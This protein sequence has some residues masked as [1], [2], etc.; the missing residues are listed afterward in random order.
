MKKQTLV[1]L[2]AAFVLSVSAC[3]AKEKPVTPSEGT[4]EVECESTD[5]TEVSIEEATEAAM[6]PGQT[7][8]G[9]GSPWIDSN[10]KENITE[11]MPV[12]VKDDFHLYVNHEW[13][14]KNNIPEGYSSNGP[15][16]TVSMDTMRKAQ[17]LI[18]DTELTGHEI[19][20]VRD[21]YWAYLDWDAKNAL[22]VE[23]VMPTVKDIQNLKTIQELSDFICDPDR[24]MFV[25]VFAGCSNDVDINNTT[26]YVTSIA[27]D[28]FLLADAAE[29][30]TRTE[31]G[32][33][34]YS[35]NKA[36][37]VNM[38]T[39]TGYQRDEAEKLYDTVIDFEAKLAEVSLTS[40]ETMDP[41]YIQ[42]TNNIM[43]MSELSQLAPEFPLERFIQ[44]QGYGAAKRFIVDEPEYFKRLN[45]LYTEDN[46]ESIKGY[47]LVNY[48][49]A[50]T[51]RLDRE[52][53]DV[54]IERANSVNGSKGNLSDEDYAFQMI[55]STLSDPLARA[56]ITKYDA[57]DKKQDITE[58]C[59]KVI[60]SYREQLK[61]EDWMSEE[62]R[63]K[64]IS[65]LDHI[66]IR[67]VY[68]DKWDD[69]SSLS[70]DGMSYT[71]MMKT[72][73]KFYDKKNQAY[74]NQK[75]DREDWNLNILECNAFYNPQDNSINIVL[76]IL[77]D[78]FYQE[79]MTKEQLY[80]SI[81]AVIGHEISHAFDTIGAQFDEN[82]N[83]ANWW[84]DEDFAAFKVKTDKLV[85]FYD[86]IVPFEGETV[87]G[88]N[89]QSEAIADIAGVKCL[90]N[91]AKEEADFDYD[92]FFRQYASIWKRLSSREFE[93]FCLTQDVHPLH[94]LRTNVTLQQFDEFYDT[95]D[96]KPG[97]GMYLAPEERIPVW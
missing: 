60:D 35:A 79:D 30:Q 77:G 9:G 97:D 39:R 38:L 73:K 31:L 6:G 89:V 49:L 10:L 58:I 74:T 7:S 8:S 45:E 57:R 41:G 54:A 51:T 50:M 53:F 4:T 63:A 22:G 65:K 82:G 81:G 14:L 28:G 36:A 70:L 12:S 66:T 92:A 46:L 34:Y 18:E 47:M 5:G 67:A 78:E 44:S 84:T 83:L 11:S 55:E 71:D 69:Y 43:T 76:G 62:T 75:V 68:P 72:L 80:G 29:Y 48:L 42:K 24:S 96:I 64:A 1:I 93:Y 40:D 21:L 2:L 16:L 52:A 88:N 20:L 59:E 85:K 26:S 13:L 94:Y 86:K 33:R 19:E 61:Q 23:P 37:A 56:Y 95:Y 32:E 90:L 91:I 3:G 25:E 27:K 17:A 15:F 87:S